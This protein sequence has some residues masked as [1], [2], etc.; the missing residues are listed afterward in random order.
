MDTRSTDKESNRQCDSK[1]EVA[2]PANNVILRASTKGQEATK[3]EKPSV[4]ADAT[5][6]QQTQTLL[7]VAQ[8]QV[9][10]P[11]NNKLHSEE[12]HVFMDSG[13]EKS[14]ITEA[15]ALRL[16]LTPIGHETLAVYTFGTS[17]PKYIESELYEL[18]LYSTH[19]SKIIQVYSIPSLTTELRKGRENDLKGQKREWVKVDVLIGSDYFWEFFKNAKVQK[20]DSGLYKIKSE[21]G[22]FF[23]GKEGAPT[24]T[25]INVAHTQQLKTENGIIST[26][27][28][29]V[30]IN[31]FWSLE[32]I[33]ITGCPVEKDDDKA[34]KLF[35]QS[36]KFINGRYEV[37]W[38]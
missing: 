2:V 10:N 15:L 38:P 9:A 1:T 21:I 36:V 34:L 28:P 26:V 31:Q 29:E 11:N 13:S 19:A 3:N 30:N 20:L 24:E 5:A 25:V 33:G 23:S 16:H 35:E 4:I 37:G 14:F 8:V 17:T 18:E 27:P 12:I 22:T 6:D 32:G 7:L